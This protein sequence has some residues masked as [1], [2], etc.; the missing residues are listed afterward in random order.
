MARRSSRRNFLKTSSLAT[1][2][3][4]VAARPTLGQSKS[5]NERLNVA[6]IGV[7]GMGAG[8]CRDM[9]AHGANIVAVCDVNDDAAKGTYE[10]FPN[11]KR[12]HDFREMFDK[13]HK[14]I[15]AVTV[16][17]PDHTHAVATMMAMKLGKHVYT[18]K[19]LTHDVYEARVLT[20]AAKKYKVVTQMGNQ[21]T[22]EPGLREAVEVIQSGAIG[23]VREVHVW[24]NR[25]V[26]PQGTGAILQHQG[27]Q[28]ALSGKGSSA[29]A[30]SHIKWDLWLGT[31]PERPYDPIYMPFKW[32]GWWDF[33][34]G[35]LG[36]MACHTAN[37]AFMA[38]NLGYPTSVEAEMSEF[39]DQT[40]P[41]WSVIRYEFPA[42]PHPKGG[43]MPPLKW[44]W[45]DGGRDK[46]AWVTRKLKELAHGRDIPDSGSLI[47]GDK[48]TLF[49]PNDYGAQYVLL[50]EKDFEGYK[51]PT[52]WLPR[53]P[54][55]GHKKEFIDACL[56]NKPEMCMSNFG[57][58]GP[59]TETV[60]LGCVAMRA[61]K[62]IEW[63]GP[64][65]K[66]TNVPEA[67]QFLRREYRKGWEL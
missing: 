38:C 55:G 42:R 64:N 11:A 37:M 22:A 51:P 43:E 1:A 2:G 59:L 50:P 13:M 21:G 14:D 47:I 53:A 3:F 36:D 33:G 67:N 32:R 29:T 34:T 44:T 41:M 63:D 12:F 48:G 8:D 66:I 56:E 20:E 52:P 24:T 28:A 26:W 19:P 31:A 54:K 27:V 58:A 9:A 4:W 23:A 30:P 10:K 65:M 45:Y 40:F 18:Q 35:A 7:G 15:D 5:P 60:V 57:Y 6:C 49:S 17:T 25:P 46:P 61:R 39:N 16:S 62:R